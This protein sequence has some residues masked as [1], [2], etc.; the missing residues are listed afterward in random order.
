MLPSISGTDI[1]R[2]TDTSSRFIAHKVLP[3]EKTE[4]EL[5]AARERLAIVIVPLAHYDRLMS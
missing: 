5:S 3:R 1:P 2:N 4:K